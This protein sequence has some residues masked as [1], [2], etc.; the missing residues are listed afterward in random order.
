MKKQFT[1][2]YTDRNDGAKIK[3][4]VR[5]YV[6]DLTADLGQ[7]FLFIEVEHKENGRIFKESV[8]LPSKGIPKLIDLLKRLK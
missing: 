5:A 7:K 8:A 3:N 1:T 4:T 2:K 6:S